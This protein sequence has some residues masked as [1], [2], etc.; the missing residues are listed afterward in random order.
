VPINAVFF[1][2]FRDSSGELLARSWFIERNEAEVRA[3]RSSKKGESWN[4]IDYYVAFGQGE[5]RDWEDARRYGFISAGQGRWYSRTLEVLEPGVRIFV[6]IPG[7]GYVGVGTV[8][9]KAVPA[10]EFRIELRGRESRLLDAPLNASSMSENSNDPEK[11]EF[12]V[13]VDWLKTVSIKE[14]VWEKGM[15]ANQNSACR[16]RNRFTLEHLYDAFGIAAET[17]GQ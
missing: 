9:D 7:T 2:T 11:S 15:F 3:S 4:G 16:L 1:R 13:R 14:A 10:A 5:H 6:C 17:A 8:L 12:V